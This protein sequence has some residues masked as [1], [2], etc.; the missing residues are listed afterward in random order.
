VQTRPGRGS[1]Q[2]IATG[3]DNTPAAGTLHILGYFIE[4]DHPTLAQLQKRLR[5]AREQRN[6]AMV[7]KL[8]ALGVKLTHQEVVD[9]AASEGSDA[10]GRPHIA[11][12]LLD[13][14]Y[15]KSIHEAFARYIG[16]NGAAYVRKDRL[17]AQQAI[18]AI[19]QAGGLASLAHPIQLELDSEGLEHAVARLSDMGLDAIE[20]HHS[21]HA[22]RHRQQFQRFAER[23]S[24]LTTGGSDYHGS[25]K[26]IP[27]A[28]QNVPFTVYQRLHEAWHKRTGPQPA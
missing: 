18:E 19:H 13:K 8:N 3:A 1:T 2:S 10:P 24:L 23:F 6:P 26:R 20:T 14:G 27:L 15:V 16:Q 7:E 11:R 4:P 9:L 25:R 22:A 21:D 28:S 17:T 12:L 5:H